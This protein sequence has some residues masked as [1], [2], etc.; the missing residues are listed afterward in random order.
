M[1]ATLRVLIADDDP[2]ARRFLESAVS[3]AGYEA[4]VVSA[5]DEAWRVLSAEDGPG[6]AVLDWMMPGLTGIEVCE[7]VRAAGLR[8]PPYLIVLTS[9]GA[10]DDVVRALRAGAD[11]HITKPFDLEELRARLAVGVRIVTLQRQLADRILE[12]EEALAH[13]QQLQGLIPICAWCRQVRSD[14]D[15][16]EQV[17]SYLARRS[18]LQF[19]HAICPTCRKRELDEARQSGAG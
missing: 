8:I 3:R 18:G 13:V 9:R 17:E 11:D 1:N 7:K 2:I 6:V 4:V 19:S 16:W 15:F 10:T 14:G 5:G 12:L